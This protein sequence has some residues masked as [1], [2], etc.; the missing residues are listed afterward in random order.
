MFFG[1]FEKHNAWLERLLIYLTGLFVMMFKATGRTLP[2]RRNQ[3]LLV[4]VGIT[5]HLPNT[6]I[7]PMTQPRKRTPLVI[8][9]LELRA[10]KNM[11]ALLVWLAR[12]RLRSIKI[13]AT[14]RMYVSAIAKRHM[15]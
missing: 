3:L 10:I 8:V 4:S 15:L 2:G 1:I 5:H 9:Q 12:C 13:T 14:M 11:S 7:A 6:P